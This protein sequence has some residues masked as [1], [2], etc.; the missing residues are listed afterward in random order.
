M[1]GRDA[2]L[3]MARERHYEFSSLRRAKFSSMSMLYELHNQGQDKFVYTCNNCKSHVETR[4]HCTVCDVCIPLMML[5]LFPLRRFTHKVSYC[6]SVLLQDFDLCVSC[7]DKDG[8]P[9]PMEKL[10]FDLDDGSSPA[11][12]KQTNLQ[13]IYS[14]PSWLFCCKA[15]KI[16][17]LTHNFFYHTGSSEIVD[18][19]VH[20]V[21]GTWLPV[22]RRQLSS[23][24]LSEDE[25]SGNAH[26]ELQE[27]DERWMPDMQAI[28]SALLLPR[29]TLPRD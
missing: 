17:T 21:A 10:G 15:Q 23:A 16:V 24:E 25:E 6:N 3:T 18:T 1:D 29:E 9:H 5:F 28:I 26:E 13:V 22:Q 27:K 20:S 14:L 19:E 4:Y 7:K 12:A 11:D 2:F 8:H